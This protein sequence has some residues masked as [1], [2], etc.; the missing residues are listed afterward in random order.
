[1]ERPPHRVPRT[2]DL[3]V[4]G[5]FCG[6]GESPESRFCER[7]SPV[8]AWEPWSGC[9]GNGPCSV[10]PSRESPLGF[11]P[12]GGTGRARP[13]GSPGEPLS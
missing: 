2:S 3:P 1:M 7:E 4:A 12:D 9:P 8:H 6:T 11:H 5:A 10:L 13:A